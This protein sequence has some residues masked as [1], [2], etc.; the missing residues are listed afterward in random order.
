M[1]LGLGKLTEVEGNAD[2][3]YTGLIV[4]GFRHN[5]IRNLVKTGTSER[6]AMSISRRKV[7]SV[8][9]RSHSVNTE[10]V[11]QAIKWVDC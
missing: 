9:D 3:R 6:V 1:S 2:P 10:D 7:Q 11:E 5:A 4:H 8:F